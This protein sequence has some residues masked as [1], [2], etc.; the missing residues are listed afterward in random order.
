M[1]TNTTTKARIDKDLLNATEAAAFLTMG[2]QTLA[3]WRSAGVGPR[4]IKVGRNV[5]YRRS[6]LLQWLEMRAVEP[7]ASR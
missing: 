7:S 2:V 4:Y 1:R 6:D 5:R 3:D